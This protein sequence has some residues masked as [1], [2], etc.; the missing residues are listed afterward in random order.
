M[1]VSPNFGRL[2]KPLRE[3]VD[4]TNLNFSNIKEILDI[5][6]KQNKLSISSNTK[7]GQNKSMS[8]LIENKQWPRDGYSQLRSVDWDIYCPFSYVKYSIKQALIS[9]FT[10]NIVLFIYT[11][12]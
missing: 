8:I 4:Y 1:I 7:F 9:I 3:K 2:D 6:K 10:Y 5:A 12:T 11:L